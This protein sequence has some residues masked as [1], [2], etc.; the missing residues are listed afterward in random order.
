MNDTPQNDS[1][2]TEQQMQEAEA[3]AAYEQ[4]KRDA[5][6]LIAMIWSWISGVA[7]TARLA[8]KLDISDA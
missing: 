8:D 7:A 6:G 2:P 1:L 4:G 3:H 5:P